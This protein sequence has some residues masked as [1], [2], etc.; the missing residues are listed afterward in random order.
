MKFF[1]TVA[2]GLIAVSS[3]AFAQIADNPIPELNV[4]KENG[5][6]IPLS[7]EDALRIALSENTSV[8][9]A[10]MDIRKTKYSREG[11]YASLAPQ[12][13]GSG[14]YQRTIKKQ[15]MYM[16]I[17][18]SSF[19]IGTGTETGSSGSSSTGEASKGGIEV[20]RW[21]TWSM[22]VT[23]A[24][25]LVNAQLWEA[26]KISDKDVELAVEKARSSRLNMVTEVKNAYF[27]T[28]LAKEAF[29]VYKSVYE[30]AVE[31]L[32]LIQKRFNVQR[33]SELE[34]VRAK[35]SVANAIPDVFDS[36]NAVSLALWQ[37]KAVMGVDLEMAIDTKGALTD[38][39]QHM[40]YDLKEN[41]DATLEG[42]STL[43]QLAIQAEQLSRNVKMQQNANL[44]TLSLALTYNLNANENTFKFSEYNW[45]PYS[46][47]GISLS[48]PIFAG[49][50]RNSA[51]RQ[52]KVQAG[53]LDLQR[54]DTERQLKIAIRQYINT[55]ETA[56]KSYTSAEIAVE[57]ANKAYEIA[58][59]SYS[60]GRSTLTDLNS[61]QLQLTQ[62]QLGVCQAI[63]KF[64]VAKSQL[65]GT[66]GADFIDESGN[67]QLNKTYGNE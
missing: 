40:F 53:E 11:T 57:T 48:I 38:Y 21:N 54:A 19:G 35:T 5:S 18:M 26:L 44:P 1:L 62:A 56:M 60:V 31:N 12:I 6:S 61:A 34:L 42:N 43:R 32:D 25:P 67:V 7:L 30:N 64:V 36:E 13:D 66:I 24:M 50:K 14:S 3:P 41:E 63:Y 37:L 58:L 55:M 16:D 9:V 47:V 20:G 22:G 51:I 4:E 28:L 23:A 59:K 8:K 52:A 39:S 46:F 17:D 45:N 49:G 65:E 2:A 33:A 27:S 29:K 15:V 10:D